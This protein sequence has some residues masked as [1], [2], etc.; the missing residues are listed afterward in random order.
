[1]LLRE[2]KALVRSFGGWWKV[3]TRVRRPNIVVIL[4]GYQGK[5]GVGFA[6][7]NPRDE[8]SGD[9]RLAWNEE[10]G[11]RIAKG[12]AEVDIAQ[13]IVADSHECSHLAWS[14]PEE[15]ISDQ[16]WCDSAGRG[17]GGRVMRSG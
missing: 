12:R 9:P 15:R 14:T 2:A 7:H 16:G 11:K 5:V 1:M 3:E 4:Q 8:E 17:E 13:Q 6:R 10:K